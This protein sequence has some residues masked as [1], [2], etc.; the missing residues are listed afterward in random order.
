MSSSSIPQLS[1]SSS[2]H[3]SVPLKDLEK[4]AGQSNFLRWRSTIQKVLKYQKVVEITKN[5]QETPTTDVE[6]DA[7]EMKNLQALL[8][9]QATISLDQQ[10]LISECETAN[11]AWTN[12]HDAFDRQN[13][14][15]SF[16]R[17]RLMH[18]QDKQRTIPYLITFF[19]RFMKTMSL[20]LLCSSHLSIPL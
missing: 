4:L 20:R 11:Q 19:I 8:T 12:L 10:Y 5:K 6:A 14:I 1:S 7:L 16:Y 3:P 13:T 18:D 2:A 17:M 9:M 15:S